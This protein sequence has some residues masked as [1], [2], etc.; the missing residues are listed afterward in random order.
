MRQEVDSEL[1]LKYYE[2]DNYHKK[3]HVNSIQISTIALKMKYRVKNIHFLAM[4]IEK[5]QKY[6]NNV[7][8]T[9]KN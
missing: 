1:L 5:P 7:N 2:H 6:H 9:D 8:N 3:F 4:Y